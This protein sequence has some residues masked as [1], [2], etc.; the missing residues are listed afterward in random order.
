MYSRDHHNV[1]SNYPPIKE[2]EREREKDTMMTAVP[3]YR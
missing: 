2:R 1:Q 3:L